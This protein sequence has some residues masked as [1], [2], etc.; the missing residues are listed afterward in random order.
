MRE[1]ERTTS[2]AATQQGV[3]AGRNALMQ[4]GDQPRHNDEEVVRLRALLAAAERRV[5]RLHEEVQAAER[6]KDE[7]LANISH[8][9]RTPMNAILGFCRVLLRDP[10]APSQTE[11]LQYIHD[12]A[13]CLLQ[14]INNALNLS[15]LAAGEL[16]LSQTPFELDSVVRD[17]MIA[18]RELARH[19]GLAIDYIVENAVP[20]RLIGDAQWLG[21]VL[22]NLLSNSLK[23]TERGE[24]HLRASLDEQQGDVAAIRLVVTDTGVG[25]A[26][27]RQQ[28]IFDAFAQADGS[29]TRRFGG[30][31]LGLSVC[32]QLVDL[33]GGQIGF[34]SR[35]GSGSSFW[36]TV[37]LRVGVTP[38][39]TSKTNAGTSTARTG[40]FGRTDAR[41]CE[42][43]DCRQSPRV[44]MAD[45]DYLARTLVE[46]LLGRAGC[47]I[48][49]AT[50]GNDAVAMVN[51]NRYDLVLMDRQLPDVD[52][53][54]A[55]LLSRQEVSGPSRGVAVVALEAEA[56]VGDGE[57]RLQTGVDAT[58]TKPIAPD[59]LLAV[60]ERLLPGCLETERDTLE[61]AQPEPPPSAPHLLRRHFEK[62][63]LA[64]D[65]RDFGHLESAAGALKTDL[66]RAEARPLADQ[67]MRVQFAARSGDSIQAARA[68]ERL[69][70][71]LANVLAEPTRIP[72]TTGDRP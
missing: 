68:I 34:R 50:N 24:I 16:K 63:C 65:D 56:L 26:P 5:N 46:M 4:A 22:G 59:S 70:G 9:V 48:D 37:P 53:L 40:R 64:L 15:R 71:L 58:L 52:A 60:V 38:R 47:L 1:Y 69:R 67:A 43:A 27:D 39:E 19:K 12:A 45:N 66:L 61:D 2:E 17:V 11:K 23:F 10:L 33:M 18:I 31:G 51:Q 28:V 6:A 41:V 55:H 20:R 25:I 29:S 3:A 72:Q 21:Q 62:L 7:F 54:A 8:E 14:H 36:V 44:L 49:T 35:P 42:D 32:K 13:E 30:L 57:P